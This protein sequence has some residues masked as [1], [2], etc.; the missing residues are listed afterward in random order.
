MTILVQ[1]TLSN[2]NFKGKIFF[3]RIREIRIRECL[4]N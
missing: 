2:S 4:S 1:S 3:I